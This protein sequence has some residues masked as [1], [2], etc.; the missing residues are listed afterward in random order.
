MRAIKSFVYL[1]EYKMY[2]ISSQ[3]F[4]G[5]TES[6]TDYRGTIE[7]EEE[8]QSGRFG[9]GRV[10][11]SILKSGTMTQENKYLHDYSYTLFEEHLEQNDKVH[12]ISRETIDGAAL[13]LNDVN[14][15]KVKAKAIFN[16]MRIIKSTLQD[17]NKLG[18]ALA[19]ASSF[20]EMQAIN[21]E[22]EELANSTGDRNTR[23][24]LRERQ[25]LFRNVESVA[26]SMGLYQEP[27]LL[28]QIGL[29]LDYGF[30]DQFE[31]QMPTDAY[32]FSANL[33]REYLRDN[34]QLLV[35]RYSRFSEKE[36]VLFGIVSQSA[37]AS[38]DPDDDDIVDDMAE[39]VP[40]HM[41]DVI[42]QFVEGISEIESQFTGKLGNEIVIDP[43]A[44]YREI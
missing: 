25:K 34:E 5:I 35:K 17:F 32:V 44:L 1:D 7:E 22:L 20:D 13:A 11:A 24:Q 29:L 16:D 21:Q 43:I 38:L 15:V 6:L 14:F 36:F 9:S 19:Y 8:S 41:K 10:M 12:N 27:K 37:I 2:S 28:E 4:E 23:A 39:G 26:K 40:Q 18:G 33:K 42:M 30:Q 31:I 3:I